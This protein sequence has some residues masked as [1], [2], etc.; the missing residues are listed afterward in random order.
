M[1][2]IDDERIKGD[3]I[4]DLAADPE[5]HQDSIRV[6]VNNG[7]VRLD[8]ILDTL[9][10]KEKAESI[11]QY[12][13]GVKSVENDLTVSADREISDLQ[14]M[15][16]IRERLDSAGL[17]SIGVNVS[18]GDAYLSGEAQNLRMKEEA[19]LIGESVS[20]IKSLD[21]S[22]LDIAQWK[23]SEDIVLADF[24]LEA[25][26][27][28]SDL[29]ISDLH[30]TSKNGNIDIEGEARTEEQIRLIDSIA[31]SIPGVHRV[32]NHMKVNASITWI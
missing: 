5:V 9:K 19:E 23:S 25:I 11:A 16:Q 4:T 22:R 17:A 18:D 14:L 12:V 8:G 7:N 28:N 13:F 32:D 27:E 21:A 29:D 6:Y 30:V 26:S 3:I 1:D 24:V 2:R 10:E 20:G 15:R 31:Q